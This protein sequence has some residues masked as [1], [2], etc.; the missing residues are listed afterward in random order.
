MR[1]PWDTLGFW[2]GS[3]PT[4]FW[5][6][7]ISKCI[8]NGESNHQIKVVDLFCIWEELTPKFSWGLL[9]L[10]L[11]WTLD[12]IFFIKILGKPINWENQKGKRAW[13][14]PISWKM[15][16]ELELR[17]KFTGLEEIYI[18]RV[19]LQNE[20]EHVSKNNCTPQ[21]TRHARYM[22]FKYCPPY[23]RCGF[24]PLITYGQTNW[25]K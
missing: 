8:F 11:S 22:F 10:S 1:M 17:K 5:G 21:H 15:N 18:S 23:C 25:I 3:F 20:N 14:C 4:H 9:L 24:H 12:G 16:E 2:G 19:Q 13:V 7:P 6:H